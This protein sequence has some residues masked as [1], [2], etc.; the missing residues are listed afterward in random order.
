M[1][2]VQMLFEHI[3]VLKRLEADKDKFIPDWKQLHAD[4]RPTVCVFAFKRSMLVPALEEKE[5][6]DGLIVI[7]L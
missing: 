2:P 1:G 6:K 3:D 5:K 7:F 4:V